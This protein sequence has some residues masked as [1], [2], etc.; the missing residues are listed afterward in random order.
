DKRPIIAMLATG[1][2]LMFA[3]MSIE[4]IITVYVAQLVPVESQVTM[5]SCVVMSA[6]ALGSILSASWLGKRACN[7]RPVADPVCELA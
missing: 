1:M 3:N 2:L 6:A 5:V 4:P 7:H